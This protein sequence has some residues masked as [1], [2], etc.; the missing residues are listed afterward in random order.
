MGEDRKVVSPNGRSL[1]DNDGGGRLCNTYY[2]AFALLKFELAALRDALRAH[3]AFG[4]LVDCIRGVN[5]V[6][7]DLLDV[8]LACAPKSP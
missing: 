2:S 5:E 3:K 6:L 8:A 4:A 1:G 7:E